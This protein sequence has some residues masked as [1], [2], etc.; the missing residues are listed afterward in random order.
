VVNRK[1][2]RVR[3]S[4]QNPEV[5]EVESR[6]KTLGLALCHHYFDHF[7]SIES[8]KNLWAGRFHDSTASLFS[9][10]DFRNILYGFRVRFRSKE[11]I[12]RK[13]NLFLRKDTL[14]ICKSWLGV[15]T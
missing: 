8:G 15:E 3:N 6:T 7:A 10:Q 14:N 13:A 4:S 9:A 5:A 12:A 2:A 1:K 11:E